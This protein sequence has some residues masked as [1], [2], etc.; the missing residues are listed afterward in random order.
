MVNPSKIKGTA[1]ETG[2]VNYLNPNGFPGAER[3]ALTGAF[4]QGDITGTPG[5][6]WEVKNC[7]T[8]SIPKWLKETEAE[9]INSGADFGILAIKPNGVG[10]T[11]AGQWW[12]VMPMA[13][14]VE[15][16]RL[17]GYGEAL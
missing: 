11:N 16:L 15:L 4:D 6:A 2:L 14:M 5:L 17:A 7:K 9:R 3:R 10:V 1:A 8:Y 12:A 13:Q